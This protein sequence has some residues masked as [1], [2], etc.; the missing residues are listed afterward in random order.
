MNIK[1]PTPLLRIRIPIVGLVA[2]A[3]FAGS[4][5][6]SAQTTTPDGTKLPDATRSAST[7]LVSASDPA[8]TVEGVVV[9][10]A[11]APTP[12]DNWKE[13][14]DHIMPEVSGTQI[15]VTKKATVIKL[16]KQPPIENNNLQEEFTKAPGFL[17]T[18]QHTPG[19]FN[20]SY[21]G[22]GNPQESEFTTVLRDGL[23]LVS[24]WIGFPTLYYL[25]LPQSISEIDFIRG[26]SSLL[27]GP[28]PA[29]A[30]NFIT[31]HPVPGTPWQGYVEGVGGAYGYYSTYF[32]A[33][34]ASGPV[35]MRVASGYAHSD[36][37]RLNSD[38]D[39]WQ[40][41]GYLGYRWSEDALTALDFYA[42]RFDGGDPGRL[43]NVHLADAHP[44]ISLTPYNE[45]WVDRYT[46]ILRHEEKF[47]DGWL[48]QAKGWFTHQEIDARAG[49]NIAKNGAVPLSTVFGYEEFNNGG[50]DIRLR[51]DWGDDTIF[52]GSVLTFGVTFY[53]GDAPFQRYTLQGVQSGNLA[54]NFGPTYLYAPRGSKADTIF[55]HFPT[56]P[57]PPAG[58][59]TDIGPTLD[60]SRDAE[61]QALFV[62]DLIRL[63]KFHVVGSF[64]LD[65][66]SVEVDSANAPWL[67]PPLNPGNKA[68][69]PDSISADH[70]VPL[71][72]FG[73]GNDFGDRNET[74]FSASSGWRPTRYFDIAGTTRTVLPGTSVPDPFHSLDFELGVHGSPYKG[75]WYDVGAFWMVFDNR[76]ESVNTDLSGQAS[77]TDFIIRNTGSSRHRGFEGEIS[78]DFLATFQHP[79]EPETPAPKDYTDYKNGN[80][81]KDSKVMPVPGTSLNDWHPLK[82]IIFSNAQYLDA[83]YIDSSLLQPLA[84]GQA[85]PANSTKTI[86]GNTPAFAP[87]FLW[88]G[89]LS[90]QREKCFDLTLS[91]V[92]V[93]QQYWQDTDV[94]AKSAVTGPTGPIRTVIDPHIAP[95]YTLNLSGFCY[96]TKN[97]RLIG[98]ISNLTDLKYYDRIF[99]NGI[100]PA[101]RRSGY[102]GLSVEF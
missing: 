7:A 72:G 4:S 99:V 75:F 22:L 71:W 78:Y 84:N 11:P 55:L 15:T 66:E 52:H 47:G 53:F 80:Y 45:D 28:E 64:R 54:V 65:H 44:S 18:E 69:S 16:D 29:P 48:L 8:P 41:D 73:M 30:V 83:E 51:K 49:A 68:I 90:F 39:L 93:S 94:G 97:V 101:P 59:Q 24:D 100:E 50:G 46:T 89:G 92:Y 37:Q 34:E 77:N 81:A 1:V 23:P 61:Y 96:V 26:G 74:Y 31:K 63:G 13:K 82:L 67:S 91:A 56:G 102:A 25:P 86:V 33:Q 57:N 62:E 19:Q 17:V 38:Y 14:R 5:F 32:S 40:A 87:Q 36:G 6:V 58:P 98:G 2:V 70:W 35:E 10:A 12:W 3:A 20:F 42:S 79:P 43:P 9:T 21:R 76:T 60:Q 85:P 88:K 27:F 95:Y